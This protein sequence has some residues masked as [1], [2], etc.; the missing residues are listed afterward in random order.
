[1]IVDDGGVVLDIAIF[2]ALFLVLR[3][4][5]FYLE[6]YS[7]MAAFATGIIGMGAVVESQ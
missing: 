3:V 5:F 4:I 2:C 6:M 1:M 7:M